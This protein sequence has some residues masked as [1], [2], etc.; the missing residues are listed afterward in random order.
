[1]FRILNLE[2]RYYL[3]FR[4]LILGFLLLPSAASAAL[5]IQAPKYIGLTSGLVGYWSFNGNDVSGVTAYDRSGNANNGT[6]TGGP[7]RT[8]GKIGQGL[9]FDGVDDYV[10]SGTASVLDDLGPVSIS[11][12]IY[13]RSEGENGIGTIIAKDTALT[14]GYWMLRMYSGGINSLSFIK[15]Y[16]T[17]DLIV[18]TV[19]NAITLNTWQYIT[20]IWDGSSSAAN[21]KIYI[22]ATEAAYVQQQNGVDAKNSDNALNLYVGNRG[23]STATFDGSIDDVRIYNRA[24]SADEIKR[25]YR[26]GA[27]LKINTSINNDSLANGLVGYWTMNA[28]DVAG[29]TA[30]DRSGQGKNGSILGQD[31][32]RTGLVGWWKLDEGSGATGGGFFRARKHRNS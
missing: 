5:I 4:I 28:P 18:A 14:S 3:G 16:S 25:L 12:W 1:M 24:L 17:T 7:T 30:Y 6:L 27:T 21:A 13:P 2:F 10:D 31:I 8:I 11:A 9:S 22:N 15:N 32:L 26:I 29:T 19:D 23:A 20:L